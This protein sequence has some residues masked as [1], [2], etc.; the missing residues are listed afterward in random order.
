[1]NLLQ[2]IKQEKKTVI[3]YMKNKLINILKIYFFTNCEHCQKT[4]KKIK[5]KK[6]LKQLYSVN[7]EK[8][9]EKKEKTVDNDLL[10]INLM[11]LSCFVVYIYTFY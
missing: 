2:K 5:I 4:K 7:K 6:N 3:K 9:D 11:L 8:F 1:M 10:K